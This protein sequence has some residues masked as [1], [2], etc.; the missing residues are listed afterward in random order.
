MENVANKEIVTSGKM[1]V[2][3][4]VKWLL[5]GI[6][7]GIVLKFVYALTVSFVSPLASIITMLLQVV[8]V[9]LAWKLS[10][11]EAFEKKT[12]NY[13]DVKKVM[14]NLIIFMVVV[15][16]LSS[17]LSFI[18]TSKEVDEIAKSELKYV[19]RVFNDDVMTEEYIELK[20]NAIKQKEQAIEKYRKDTYTQLIVSEIIWTIVFFAVLPLAK[21]EILKYVSYQETSVV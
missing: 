7:F 1:T 20:E 19:E 12:I 2:S 13:Y 6:V 8:M 9:Y 3:L 16:I 14:R 17:A 4:A 21:K 10:I 11:K 5:W 15:C 18:T